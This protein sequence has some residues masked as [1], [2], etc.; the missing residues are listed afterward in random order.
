MLA[1]LDTATYTTT[2]ND[3]ATCMSDTV[4]AL[5]AKVQQESSA[6]SE[7]EENTSEQ[8]WKELTPAILNEADAV[9]SVSFHFFQQ[10]DGSE[11]FL[12]NW[13]QMCKFMDAKRLKE[14]QQSC[15]K[16]HVP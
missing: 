9:L 5:T 13:G 12:G 14:L 4:E 1:S 8:A 3:V 2:D 10:Q 7:R 6:S 15:N 11:A 16:T